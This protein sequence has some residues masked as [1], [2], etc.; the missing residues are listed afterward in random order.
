M[1]QA[2]IYSRVST[3]G[4]ANEGASLAAQVERARAWCKGQGY[5]VA[6]VYEDAGLSGGKM[7][8]RPGLKKALDHACSA[9]GVL[10]IYSLSRM[11]RSTADTLAIAERLQRAGAGMASL[12]EDIRTDTASGKMV[13]RLLAVLAEFERDLVSERTRMI[14][15]HKRARGERVGG[16]TP[17]FGYDAVDGKIRPN[18]VEQKV[19]ALAVKLRGMGWTLEA[20]AGELTRRNIQTKGGKKQWYPQQIKNVLARAAA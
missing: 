19:I 2:I 11:A 4:Q 17:P 12:S 5:E 7:N 15:A 8:N 20:V 1:T 18:P 10:V 14:F 9:K 6:G 13:F 16:M 3:P